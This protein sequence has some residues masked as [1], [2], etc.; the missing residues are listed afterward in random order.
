MPVRSSVKRTLSRGRE[1]RSFPGC[2][3][4]YAPCAG[5][6][7]W[8]SRSGSSQNQSPPATGTTRPTP[9]AFVPRERQIN[10]RLTS[11]PTAACDEVVK[12]HNRL[13]AEAKLPPLAISCS[14]TAAAERHAKDMAAHDKM[15]H[16][17]SDGSSSID[18]IKAKGYHYRRRRRKHR[19]RPLHDRRLMK[20]WMDSPHHKTEHP[21]QFFPDRRGLR[22]R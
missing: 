17:G 5:L 22:N 3:V 14:F 21:R 11:T 9:A 2:R 19:R 16:K 20:G 10:P 7:P 12:A 8:C 4:I 1:A 15:T 6:E 13:R 18:R